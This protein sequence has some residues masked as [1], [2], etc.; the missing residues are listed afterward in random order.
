M[1]I[2]IVGP[3]YPLRGGI[4]HHTYWLRR[5]LAE[6]GHTVQV[7]SFRK[8]YPRL[9]FPGTTE[10][11]FSRLKLDADALPIL[12]PLG[13][14]TWLKAF[15]RIGEFAPQLVVFQWWQPFFGPLVGSLARA[16]GRRGFNVVIECHNVFPHEGSPIDRWLIKFAFS[17]AD[18][19]ITHSNCD[20]R[21][22]AEL[23]PGKPVVVC[24]LPMLEEFSGPKSSRRAGRTILFFGKVRKYKGL[25]ILLESL[26]KVLR[27]F[28]CRLVVVGEFY[29]S[30]QKY[31]ELIRRLGIEGKVSIDNRYVPNE[32]LPGIFE[33]ADVL[34]LPYLS[35]SSSG[36]AQIAFSNALPV[37]ASNAGGLSEVVID[38][39]NGLVF[40]SGDSEAL[41]ERIIQYFDDELGPVF[42][43]NLH[44]SAAKRITAVDIIERLAANQSLA[45]EAA[46]L[47]TG[48]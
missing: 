37:I 13:P 17:P 39:V 25:S 29:D 40:S 38:G 30:I 24:S 16:I 41:A 20:L 1:K 26:P 47:Q 33:Q 18:Q 45:A 22:V 31:H 42:S 5:E 3:A 15:R 12:T 35:A 2:T 14:L 10:I 6:R 9:L 48:V 32:E 23:V 8:L 7:I 11:D 44:T 46:N 19:L 34:I 21:A 27:Q 43:E 36:I 4:A 28:D